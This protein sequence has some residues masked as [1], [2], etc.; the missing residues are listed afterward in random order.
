MKNPPHPDVAQRLVDF[1]L[2]A[3]GQALWALPVGHPK[4]PR[5]TAL[6]RQPIRKDVYQA[7]AGELLSGTVNPYEVGQTMNLDTGLWSA[8]Y[9]LLRQL[10]WA[11]A[12]RNVDFLKAAKK[13]LIDT[14][15]A[16]DRLALF[17]Q[18]PDNVATRE[19]VAATNELLRDRKQRD[20]IVTD[21]VAFFRNQYEQ[22]AR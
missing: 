14:N 4:G 11:A 20:I 2:S 17:N 3:D 9:G 8:S 15:F 13:K 6:G 12:V 19:A 1:V 5:R 21:W 10:V 18:L 7:Y 22:V 16:A